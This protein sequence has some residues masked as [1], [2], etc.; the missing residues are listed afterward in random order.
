VTIDPV[1]LWTVI[2]LLVLAALVTL[3]CAWRLR[4]LGRIAAA[5]REWRP[6]E[7]RIAGV[8]IDLR[9]AGDMFQYLPVVAYDYAVGGVSY[10]GE[11][12][13]LGPPTTFT[14]E[15]RAE[16]FAN[17]YA[18]GAPVTAWVD[19]G[20]PRAAVLERRAPFRT[21]L[22]VGLVAV[23]ALT[24]GGI[25]ILLLVPGVVGPGAALKL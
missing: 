15:G 18:V 17:R 22:I 8:R 3:V 1:I 12:V 11:T 9:D 10:R 5:C 23:W 24:L 13:T 7:A 20:D 19:P 25:A 4:Q 14:F 6:V 16:R 2:G 21:T